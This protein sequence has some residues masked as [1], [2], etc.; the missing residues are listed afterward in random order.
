MARPKVGTEY[1][2]VDLPSGK[3]TD[4]YFRIRRTESEL[5]VERYEWSSA[6]WIADGEMLDYYMGFE[7][8]A[9]E[10]IA[11]EIGP[12]ACRPRRPRAR[13]DSGG[14]HP[15]ESLFVSASVTRCA[16]FRR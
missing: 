4:L 16:A 11:D 12:P 1:Y 15:Q 2:R 3:R 6:A 8:G 9:E 7:P 5:H 13:P 10:L 14:P